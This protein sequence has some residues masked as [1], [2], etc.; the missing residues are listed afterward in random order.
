MPLVERLYAGTCGLQRDKRRRGRDEC[1]VASGQ[2]LLKNGVASREKA[3]RLNQQWSAPLAGDQLDGELP[4]LPSDLPLLPE[5]LGID[6]LGRIARRSATGAV[7][8]E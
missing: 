6:L 8:D 4:R 1:R 3:E 2:G 7:G 5:D